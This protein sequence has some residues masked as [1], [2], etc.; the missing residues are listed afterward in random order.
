MAQVSI[1]GCPT[2]KTI[3]QSSLAPLELGVSILFT[4]FQRDQKQ[5]L[6]ARFY[7]PATSAGFYFISCWIEGIT[8]HCKS[9]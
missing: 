7:L 6:P 3:F 1:Q 5:A 4:T 2:I 9:S 8:S